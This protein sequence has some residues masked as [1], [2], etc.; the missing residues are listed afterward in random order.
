MM[1][2]CLDLFTCCCFVCVWY[3]LICGMF[4][5]WFVVWW[6]VLIVLLLMI[7]FYW[8]GLMSVICVFVLLLKLGLFEC[9]M[10]YLLLVFY[11]WCWFCCL[12]V[13]F[14]LLFCLFG[15]DYLV[16]VCCS[17]VVW[18]LLLLLLGYGSLW[19]C[20]VWVCWKISL[21]CWFCLVCWGCLAL[22]WIILLF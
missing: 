22:V 1:T 12:R 15:C 10:C 2:V 8:F 21:V 13:C 6:L 16:L 18:V 5:Y 3:D 11:G 7:T 17:L 19:W 9:L 20:W 14:V 4:G